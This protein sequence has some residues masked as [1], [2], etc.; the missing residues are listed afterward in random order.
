MGKLEQ[1][2]AVLKTIGFN[3]LKEQPKDLNDVDLIWTYD[4]HFLPYR[5]GYFDTITKRQRVNHIIQVQPLSAKSVIAKVCP[6]FVPFSYNLPVEMNAW[7]K[8][9]SIKGAD[10]F[11]WVLK[12][13]EHRGVKFLP[14]PGEVTLGSLKKSGEDIEN[15]IIQ[16]F[17]DKPLLIDNY[18]F[19]FGIYVLVTSSLPTRVYIHTTRMVMRFCPEPYEPFDPTNRMSYVIEEGYKSAVEIPSI[20]KYLSKNY[21]RY[22]T[23]F[24]Y[25]EDNGYDAEKLRSKVLSM[26]HR[27]IHL[28]KKFW[29]EPDPI[30]DQFTDEMS[31]TE[32]GTSR[33]FE[34]LRYDFIIENLGNKELK[35]WLLEVNF[36]P[37]L[38]AQK[39]TLAIRQLLFDI[40]STIGAT[41][42]GKP[43]EDEER[44]KE[45]GEFNKED[46]PRLGCDKICTKEEIE[47]EDYC[48]ICSMETF[49]KHAIGMIRQ[50][51]SEQMGKRQFKRIIP[52][53]PSR[54]QSWKEYMTHLDKFSSK[55]QTLKDKILAT[56][57]YLACQMQDAW[58]SN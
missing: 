52:P 36:S 19:D 34:L 57:L 27:S 41:R 6:L 32:D 8:M 1:V 51:I 23:L 29:S 7:K 21:S 5:K 14:N 47:R 33:N 39:Y 55:T 46:L 38:Q 45:S 49:P 48:K 9:L 17:I 20:N 3:V 15:T 2:E 37:N 4:S 26:I 30:V 58:C 44:G 24:K 22:D 12:S 10:Q 16:K 50:T 31:I 54:D 40:L 28:S 25:L 53:A 18:K 13:K 11:K 56:W 35:P 43:W 42:H